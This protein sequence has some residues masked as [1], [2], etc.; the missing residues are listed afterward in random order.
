MKHSR[1]PFNNN[2]MR[3]SEIANELGVGCERVRQIEVKALRDLRQKLKDRG[4]VSID[5]VV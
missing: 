2:D 4:I 1:E 3:Q 5:Q